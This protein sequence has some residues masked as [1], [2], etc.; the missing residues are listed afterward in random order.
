VSITSASGHAAEQTRLLH[1]YD[2]ALCVRCHRG[3]CCWV[4]G[5]TMEVGC[6]ALAV[7]T[8]AGS[9]G[10][11]SAN[12]KIMPTTRPSGATIKQQVSTHRSD[13][14]LAK[15][16]HGQPHTM[17]DV[18][19]QVPIHGGCTGEG[20]LEHGRLPAAAVGKHAVMFSLY[21]WSSDALHSQAAGAHA[22]VGHDGR[23]RI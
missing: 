22:A 8:T 17:S 5:N 9:S 23:N 14:A 15:H 21:D 20:A 18:C 6:C 3:A 19:S 1:R 7:Q 12:H 10:H 2:I 13:G 4:Q 16:W 11:I